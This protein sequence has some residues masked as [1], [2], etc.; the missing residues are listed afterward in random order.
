METKKPAEPLEYTRVKTCLREY[1]QLIHV[2]RLN[3][4]HLGITI[5]HELAWCELIANFL[6]QSCTSHT[7]WIA[8]H[9]HVQVDEHHLCS[10][11]HKL[12]YLQGHVPL[13]CDVPPTLHSFALRNASQPIISMGSRPCGGRRDS[14]CPRAGR[15]GLC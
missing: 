8:S 4:Q 15:H 1:A 7:F 2:L 10:H 3:G 5:A 6:V 11:R 13:R 9:R 14:I 12:P